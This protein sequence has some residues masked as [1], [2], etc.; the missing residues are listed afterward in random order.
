VIQARLPRLPRWAGRYLQLVVHRHHATGAFHHIL[1]RLLLLLIRH[2]AA[3]RHR[4]AGRS[5]LNRWSN[6]YQR[7]IVIDGRSHLADQSRVGRR[8]LGLRRLTESSAALRARELARA[9]TGIVPI[10]VAIVIRLIVVRRRASAIRR[11]GC[12]AFEACALVLVRAACCY[13]C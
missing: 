9:V 12:F 2:I 5:D 8:R 10:V 13:Q 3:Q 4:S 11:R 1:D 7:R 6:R